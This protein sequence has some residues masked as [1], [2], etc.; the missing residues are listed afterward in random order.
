MDTTPRSPLSVS[1]LLDQ[2]R[3]AIDLVLGLVKVSGEISNLTRAASGHVYFSLKDERAQV[4]CV[5]FRNRAHLNGFQLEHGQHVEVFAQPAFYEARGDFQL[6]IDAIRLAGTGALYEA[7]L[8]RREQLASEGLFNTEHKQLLPAFVRRVGVITSPQAAAWKDVV[9]TVT[10][11]A[12]HVSLLLYPAQVQGAEAPASLIAAL[13]KANQRQEVDLLILCRGG[14]SLEDLWAFNDEM[15]ARALVDSTI[16]IITGIGHE[17]DLTIADLAADVRAPTP[18]AAA[19]LAA[20]ETEAITQ[21]I[22]AL[23]NRLNRAVALKINNL[24]LGLD[25]QSKRLQHPAERIRRSRSDLVSLAERLHQSGERALRDKRSPCVYLTQRWSTTPRPGISQ[26]Q[27]LDLLSQRLRQRGT[28]LLQQHQAHLGQVT[29]QLNALDP[30]A[31]LKRGYAIVTD[32]DGNTLQGVSDATIGRL[33]G[34]RLHDGRFEA[35]VD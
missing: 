6:I 4:R 11:R 29:E 30:E 20:V 33:L 35:T 18:T 12:T 32:A 3:K 23:T 2:A 7:F 5:M 16:P 10:R 22:R 31:V 24:Q 19:E 26:K 28:S 21:K 34:I 14:G 8:K 13:E 27:R 25:L 17:T 15:L 9:A 1:E